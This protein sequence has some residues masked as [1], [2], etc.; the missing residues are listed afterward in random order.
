M[1]AF[2]DGTRYAERPVGPPV[3]ERAALNRV[4]FHSTISQQQETVR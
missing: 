4:R 3:S 2:R 1:C